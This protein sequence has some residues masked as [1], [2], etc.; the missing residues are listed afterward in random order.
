MEIRQ[1][2]LQAADHIGLNPDQFSFLERVTPEK[3]GTPACALGWIGF[4]AGA[5][6]ENHREA[7]PLLGL[8]HSAEGAW[9]FYDRCE[10]LNSYKW[11]M[12]A[13]NCAATLRLYAD[14]YHPAP[15]RALIPASVRAIF[16]MTPVQLAREFERA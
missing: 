11:K 4:F 3:C 8:E 1:A 9:K 12:S 14:K 16:D 10:E 6:G 7:L 13:G 2:I 15:S 5:R